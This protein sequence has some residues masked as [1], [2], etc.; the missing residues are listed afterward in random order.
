[1][2]GNPMTHLRQM[3]GILLVS[4][5]MLAGCAATTP[6]FD[7]AFG[8]GIRQLMAQQIR[9]PDAPEANRDRA[10]DGL[11]GRTAR[12]TMERY[13]KAAGEPTRAAPT[14]QLGSGNE[15]SADR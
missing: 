7:A 1:M 12:E 15:Q 6:T 5:T 9:H 3:A 13:V 8:Q 11:D 10:A 14:F 4:A 2:N